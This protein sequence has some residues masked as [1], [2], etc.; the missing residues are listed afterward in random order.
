[1]TIF[2]VR[3]AVVGAQ[4]SLGVATTGQVLPQ[5]V[6]GLQLGG[7]GAFEVEDVGFATTLV[8]K[9]GLG[10]SEA[11]LPRSTTPRG[12]AGFVVIRFE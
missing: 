7:E 11:C 8:E 3:V 12:G 2:M 4:D 5:E 10:G 9:G 1:M 6:T